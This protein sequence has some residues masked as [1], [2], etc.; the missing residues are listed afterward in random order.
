M[1]NPSELTEALQ[2][3][4]MFGF[5]DWRYFYFPKTGQIL[6]PILVLTVTVLL[7]HVCEVKANDFPETINSLQVNFIYIAIKYVCVHAVYTFAHTVYKYP[8]N[9]KVLVKWQLNMCS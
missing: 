1:W 5:S 9:F 2:F 6:R 8:Y 3:V 7:S 4:I